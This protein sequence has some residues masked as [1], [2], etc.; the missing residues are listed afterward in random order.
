MKG[1][2]RLKEGEYLEWSSPCVLRNHPRLHFLEVE[3]RLCDDCPDSSFWIFL[4]LFHLLTKCLIQFVILRCMIFSMNGRQFVCQLKDT[5]VLACPSTK[6]VRQWRSPLCTT[7]RRVTRKMWRPQNLLF[8][9]LN[10]DSMYFKVHS[11]R[12]RSVSG[13]SRLGFRK[14]KSR[15]GTSKRSLKPKSINIGDTLS[16]GGKRSKS[17][18]ASWIYLL[19]FFPNSVSLGSSAIVK[20]PEQVGA[21]KSPGTRVP[22]KVPR[23]SFLLQEN[24]SEQPDRHG[25]RLGT[26]FPGRGSKQGFSAR[27]P[28]TGSQVRFPRGSQEQVP[29]QGF[30]ARGS[31]A[32]FPGI[33]SQA[34]FPGIRIQQG[35]QKRFPARFPSK[36]PRQ[37]NQEQIPKQGFPGRGY[38][39]ECCQEEVPRQGSQA[40][41]SKVPR[42][43]FPSKGSQ[44]RAPSKRFPCKGSQEKVPK[45]GSQEEVPKPGFQEEFSRNRFPSKISRYSFSKQNKVPRTGFQTSVSRKRFPGRGVQARF[46][47]SWF[48]SNV[49]RKR[50]PSKVPS[51]RFQPQVPRNRCPYKV[52]KNRFTSEVPR[53]FPGK[54]SQAKFPATESQARLLGR[55]SQARFPGRGSQARVPSCS[56]I[57]LL[58]NQLFLRTLAWE[59]VPASLVPA[60]NLAW[61]RFLGPCLGTVFWEPYLHAVPKNLISLA[62]EL[63]PGYLLGNLFLG[64]CSG[65]F[66]PDSVSLGSSATPRTR[67]PIK[68]TRNRFASKVTRNDFQ[69][70]FPR[71]GSQ[72]RFPSKGSRNS[73]QAR[74]PGTGSQEQVPRNR[75]PSKVPGNRFPRKGCKKVS[76]QGLQDQV[77]RQGSQEQVHKQ[78]VPRT[79]PQVP[80]QGF[81]GTGFL[82]G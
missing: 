49:S 5:R 47:A 59:P 2:D 28:G 39:E 1:G 44:A 27:F 25:A 26:R 35:S 50:F 71:T 48:P 13:A 11:F 72:A 34:R 3:G 51:H 30:P 36:V 75:F 63:L 20:V 22:R 18:M 9:K 74:F 15:N 12:T 7:W 58:G 41:P 81:Q 70:R 67:F 29:K 6:H 54:G 82:A 56:W 23:K 38:Q 55:G 17:T 66:F 62:W 46:P 64:T 65:N 21:A 33:G 8:K 24:P 76:K 60:W 19:M 16:I 10:S 4:S 43:R 61:K 78:G 80:K 77:L 45:Q 68:F 14:S 73:C 79:V 69:V 40:V 57:F 52:P 37:A 53:M 32:R 31:Q 42:N